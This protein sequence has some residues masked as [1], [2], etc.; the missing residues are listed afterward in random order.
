MTQPFDEQLTRAFDALTERLHAQMA[1]QLLVTARQIAGAAESDR[2][3]AAEAA[4]REAAALAEQQVAQRLREEFATREEQIREA[5]RAE[6]FEAGQQQAKSEAQSAQAARDA[7]SRAAVDAAN[8]R[9]EAANTELE[10]H[11][12]QL[13][14]LRAASARA[15][16]GHAEALATLR[17]GHEAA[18][19]ALRAEH[20]AAHAAL[21][22][23][24]EAVLASLRAEY[25]TELG[26]ARAEL[27]AARLHVQAAHADAQ[28]ALAAAAARAGATLPA[29]PGQAGA[30][31]AR[32]LHA[33]R[34]LDAS[35]SL[36][37]TLDAL[38]AAARGESSR[39]VVF[40]VRGDVLRSW[41]HAGFDGAGVVATFDLPLA[42]AGFI[43]DAVRSASS[44]R[45]PADSAGR[46]RFASSSTGPLVAVPL[47]MNGQVIAVLCAEE[48][49]G[50]ADSLTPTFEVLARHAARVLESLTALRLAQ[51]A[52]S[53]GAGASPPR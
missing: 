2:R 39:V 28:A 13:A 1:D 16:S 52:P 17:A 14:D 48:E 32:V 31:Q 41:S 7:E 5:A 35:S 42:D 8:T 33:V 6:W 26:D 9:L 47:A 23:E 37:Q 3:D 22:T 11:R 46:P 19:T 12:T 36:S 10:A 50:T 20:D 18:L 4:A 53:A 44:R 49:P 30:N 25:D 21:R 27:E 34:A 29:Q 51:L 45:L 24:H 15:E 40:L 38:F 43:A